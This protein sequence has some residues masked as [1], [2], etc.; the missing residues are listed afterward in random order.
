MKRLLASFL[1]V[2]FC[3]ST[4]LA[5]TRGDIE[6]ECRRIL[7]DPDADIWTDTVLDDRA[8]LGQIDIVAKTWCLEAKA[9]EDTVESTQEYILPNDY[10][11]L[12]RVA[13]ENKSTD[14]QFDKLEYTTVRRLDKKESG[15]Q[16]A[17]DGTPTKYYEYRNRVGLYP[18]PN[19]DYAGDDKLMIDYVE[20]PDAFSDD[21]TVPFNSWRKLYPYHQLIV[22]Y[23]VRLCFID[24]GQ[25]NKAAYFENLY[26][27]G[28]EKMRKTL[29][30][31]PDR[32]GSVG[33]NE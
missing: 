6:T 25:L 12:I 28:V 13:I 9:T 16:G 23:V 27:V 30:I 18:P 7:N 19:S 17:N 33:Y 5:L 24:I 8:E 15:W 2:I 1:I 20:F 21:D 22:W 32:K 26:N 3:I 31:K 11:A 14:D 4:T 10:L 29:N